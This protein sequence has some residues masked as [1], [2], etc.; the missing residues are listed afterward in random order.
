MFEPLRAAAR[1]R[2]RAS[3]GAGAGCPYIVGEIIY[4]VFS[5]IYLRQ[6]DLISGSRPALAPMV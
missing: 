3:V 5:E 4:K 2:L 6:R 1:E